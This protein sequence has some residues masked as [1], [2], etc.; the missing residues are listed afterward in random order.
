MK[1]VEINT[2]NRFDHVSVT[3]PVDERGN[4]MIVSGEWVGWDHN[5]IPDEPAN[6]LHFAMAHTGRQVRNIVTA[7]RVT[8]MEYDDEL[9]FTLTEL[10]QDFTVFYLCEPAWWQDQTHVRMSQS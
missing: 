2:L 6:N 1:Q 5:I 4:Y 7:D 9:K 8:D 3:F 10:E